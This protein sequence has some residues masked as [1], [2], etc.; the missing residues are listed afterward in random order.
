MYFPFSCFSFYANARLIRVTLKHP[1]EIDF[2]H[3]FSL[4][5]RLS[6]FLMCQICRQQCVPPR[7]HLRR[8]LPKSSVTELVTL[9]IL[10]CSDIPFF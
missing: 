8:E 7:C 5:V 9:V 2:E 6:A 10:P 3:A 1:V 4:L